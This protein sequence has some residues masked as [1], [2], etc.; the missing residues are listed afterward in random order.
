M[1]AQIAKQ[2]VGS[3]DKLGIIAHSNSKMIGL[4][5]KIIITPPDAPD[6]LFFP[7]GVIDA[8]VL[9]AKATDISNLMNRF[10][11]NASI[12]LFSCN[13]GADLS[14]L[15][16]FEGAFNLTQEDS[17]PAVSFRIDGPILPG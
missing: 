4:A 16:S 3:I 17:E 8:G 2:K 6:A 12:T 15:A 9:Q 14:L 7:Q 13:S 10:A 1:L 5:G 11:A